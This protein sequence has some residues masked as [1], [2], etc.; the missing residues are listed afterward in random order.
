MLS[1]LYEAIFASLSVSGYDVRSQLVG[2]LLQDGRKVPGYLAINAKDAHGRPVAASII[3]AQVTDGER[4]WEV[5][6]QRVQKAVPGGSL[7]PII[8]EGLD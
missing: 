7:P 8:V 4:L 6:A 2:A 3:D 5:A 1:A